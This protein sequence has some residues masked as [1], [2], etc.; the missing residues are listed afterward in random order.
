MRMA[1]STSRTAEG[2]VFRGRKLS[3]PGSCVRL[4]FLCPASACGQKDRV[5]DVSSLTSL[6]TYTM[7]DGYVSRRSLGPLSESIAAWR[8]G[9]FYFLSVSTSFVI[10][11]LASPKTIMVL[12][13]T[14]SSFS[15]PAKPGLMLRLSTITVRA[16]STL[17]TGIP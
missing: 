15:I 6:E 7:T 3:D 5:N 16:S 13:R 10:V 8:S 14:N 12:G 4:L 9:T 1:A 2:A 17:S 11:A